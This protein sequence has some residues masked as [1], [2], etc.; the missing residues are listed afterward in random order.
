VD[1]AKL[2]QE[3]VQEYEAVWRSFERNTL[4]DGS[5]PLSDVLLLGRA[6]EGDPA[7][8]RRYLKR[9]IFGE[10]TAYI[11]GK[12]EFCGLSFIADRRAYIP[13][14]DSEFLVNTVVETAHELASL[15]KSPLRILE[16]GIGGASIAITVKKR[17][18]DLS[19]I[20]GIDIDAAALKLAAENIAVHNV[21]IQLYES[22]VFE[23][24]PPDFLPDLIYSNPPW[25]NEAPMHY[26]QRPVTY[27][28]QMPKIAS[29]AVDGRTDL[30]EKIIAGDKVRGWR[31]EI[32]LYNG[33]M[34]EADVT[35]LNALC[36]H[37]RVVWFGD[38]RYSLVHCRN[39]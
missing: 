29:F 7:R 23:S 21:D 22:D 28:L 38:H 39:E 34:N 15:G 19:S 10:S 16:V 20:V 35:R 3:S 25:G 5:V 6:C 32:L 9:R 14:W 31:A 1:I 36:S 8:L 30:H 17:L 18:G 26:D 2:D 24:L 27:F 4:V 37:S 33:V 11:L 12:Q 13:D